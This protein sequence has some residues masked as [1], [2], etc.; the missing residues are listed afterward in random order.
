MF[1][2]YIKTVRSFILD[3][4]NVGNPEV[5]RILLDC[6]VVRS[7]YKLEIPGLSLTLGKKKKKH[8]IQ[9]SELGWHYC[10]QAGR[11]DTVMQQ[12]ATVEQWAPVHI[13][14]QRW[15][16]I[17]HPSNIKSIIGRIK[18]SHSSWSTALSEITWIVNSNQFTTDTSLL[19]FCVRKTKAKVTE[20]EWDKVMGDTR[21]QEQTW[22]ERKVRR[23]R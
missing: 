17:V 22:E 11:R 16:L 12:C 23:W 10:Q 14:N 20:W 7:C 3:R 6:V 18:W 9:T 1:C 5:S 8:L 4:R 21:W 2:K 13:L 19:G 15:L